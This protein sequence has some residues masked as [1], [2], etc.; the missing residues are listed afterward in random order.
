MWACAGHRSLG[1]HDYV[2]LRSG[3]VDGTEGTSCQGRAQSAGHIRLGPSLLTYTLH[4]MTRTF[5]VG[6]NWKMN[7]SVKEYQSLINH[8][9]ESQLDP[10]TGT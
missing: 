10:K 3:P 8:L 9:T 6:G 2:I 5:F 4:K 1:I 7:G